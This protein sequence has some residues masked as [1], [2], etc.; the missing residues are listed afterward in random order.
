[1]G[2][3]NPACTTACGGASAASWTHVQSD[4]L[5]AVNPDSPKRDQDAVG[6]TLGAVAVI[7]AC[8][9]DGEWRTVW[10]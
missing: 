8:T 6:G 2:N 5:E 7:V 9:W 1:M 4:E 3:K 10:M